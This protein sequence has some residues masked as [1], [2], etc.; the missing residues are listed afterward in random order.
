MR[1][2]RPLLAA[3]LLAV[4]AVAPALA[5]E[6]TPPAQQ[7]SFEGPFGS[8]DIAAAQRGFQVYSEVCSVCHSMDYLH[9]RDLTGIG[10]TEDQIKAIA[11]AVT[12]PKGLD[13]QGNVKDG[14]ATPADQFK[15]PYPL[16]DPSLKIV[17]TNE[18]ASRAAHNG[19]L[20]PD[21]SLIVNAREGGPDYVYGI[22]TGFS[23]PPP[24]MQMQEGMNYNE[25]FPG[26]QIAMPQPLHDDQVTYADGT[27]ATINQMA[28]D[29]VTFLYWAANPE[30]VERKQIGWRWVLFFLI[31]AGLTY[32]VKRKVW[33]DVH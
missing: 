33:A 8:F 32:A 6:P 11:A 19:A 3:A 12:V 25:Y 4:A 24:G 7:W 20:P 16:D 17:R 13:D 2:L 21:L 18:Q 28:H 14:P 30:M 15:S 5:Q 22:L 1:A 31:M 29:V 10:L 23:E 26:H 9:Y 27:P